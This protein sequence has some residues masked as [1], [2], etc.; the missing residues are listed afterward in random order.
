MISKQAFKSI[1]SF[2]LIDEKEKNDDET[3]ESTFAKGSNKQSFMD[4]H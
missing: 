1:L 4:N 3:R 2:N